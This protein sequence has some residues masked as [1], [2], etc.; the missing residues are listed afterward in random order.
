MCHFGDDITTG[1]VVLWSNLQ[2]LTTVSNHALYY[3]V[4]SVR[5]F[6]ADISTFELGQLNRADNTLYQSLFLHCYTRI[7]LHRIR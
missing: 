7:F 2:S 1:V 4:D 6:H 5:V 3:A